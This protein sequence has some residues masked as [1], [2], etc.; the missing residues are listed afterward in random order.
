M[1]APSRSASGQ[2]VRDED[3]RLARLAL[4]AEHLV[5]HVAADQRVEGA[6]RLVVEHHLRVGGERAGHADAL[7]H[8]AGELVGELVL[9]LLQADQLQHRAGAL[10]ALP[11]AHPLDLETERDVVD[12]AAVR[13]QAEVLEDHRHVL[14]AQVP[15]IGLAGAGDVVL[16]DPDRARPWARS[17]GSACARAST[18][19]SPTVP[20]R[21]TP[22][23]A[24]TSSET[25]LTAATQ[26][27][28]VR[29][30]ERGRSAS[31]VPMMRSACGPK[32]FQTPA[33]WISG[34]PVRTGRAHVPRE[35]RL[36]HPRGDIPVCVAR[37]HAPGL[38]APCCR[39]ATRCRSG[40]AAACRSSRRRSTSTP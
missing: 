17:G 28:L 15:Q 3:H 22:R 4:Q 23:P 2:V 8:A 34:S 29:N 38:A 26:P 18:C 39:A 37:V 24:T 30:S 16:G 5:L 21:R 27:V 36:A 10:E 11:L 20:S 13:E 7:L 32:I 31:G 1:R 33:A 25:S 35:D 19:R 40:R 9:D 14:P 12:H 6:E